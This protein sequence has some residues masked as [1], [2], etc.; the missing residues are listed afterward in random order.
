MSDTVK[1]AVVKTN[2]NSSWT[3]GDPVHYNCLFQYN[4]QYADKHFSMGEIDP[5]ELEGKNCALC[6]GDWIAG[7]HRLKPLGH[8]PHSG[9]LNCGSKPET[10]PMDYPI[11]VGFGSAYVSKD[12]IDV[13]DGEEAYHN[14]KEPPTVADA[15]K[16][17]LA[18]PD[19]DWRI[20]IEGPMGG[21]VYQR[22]EEGWVACIRLAGFA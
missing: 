11:V 17:Y 7:P 14:G 4:E 5:A 18:E 1:Y 2:D 3:M 22:H 6:N 16:L 8:A 9:C 21:V 20:H 10:L 12:G 13:L 15:E 19:H